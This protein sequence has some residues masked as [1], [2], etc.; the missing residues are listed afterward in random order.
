MKTSTLVV[1]NLVG[2]D[3]DG[4]M[5]YVIPNDRIDDQFNKALELA[6]GK[7]LNCDNFTDEEYDAH[8]LI[9]NE[10]ASVGK[11]GDCKVD[12]FKVTNVLIDRIFHLGEVV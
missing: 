4:S 5:F 10:L 3:I 8:A 9:D 1:F 7:F 2:A 12:S 6:K 11:F